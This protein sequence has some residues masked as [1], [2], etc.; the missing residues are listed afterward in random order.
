[1]WELEHIWLL[2]PNEQTICALCKSP[3][4]VPKFLIA[5]DVIDISA[6]D[7]EAEANDREQRHAEEDLDEEDIGSLIDFIHDE[8]PDN[9]EPN[10]EPGED[11]T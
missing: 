3:F 7:D 9:V 8:E 5:D 1:M 6:T 4:T 2:N 11:I 10:G